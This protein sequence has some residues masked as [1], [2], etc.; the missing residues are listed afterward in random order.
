MEIPTDLC[1]SELSLSEG[2]LKVNTLKAL[3]NLNIRLRALET[4]SVP[5]PLNI[6]E[7]RLPRDAEDVIIL[8]SEF[9]SRISGKTGKYYGTKVMRTLVFTD[10]NIDSVDDIVENEFCISIAETSDA[11]YDY[12]RPDPKPYNKIGRV[13]RFVEGDGDEYIITG[14]IANELF[15]YG[16]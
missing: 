3:R 16:W 6:Y 12:Y 9:Q 5:S 13:S 11:L 15:N 7:V 14:I 8:P 1:A 10:K 2:N 4:A